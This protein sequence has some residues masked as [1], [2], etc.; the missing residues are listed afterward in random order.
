MALFCYHCPSEESRLIL[1]FQG[2]Q[3]LTPNLSS[4][5]ICHYLHIHFYLRDAVNLSFL[6][7]CTYLI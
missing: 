2:L 3:I 6:L 4:S 1:E 7:L 5:F